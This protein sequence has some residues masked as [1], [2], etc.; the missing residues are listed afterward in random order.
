MDF[1]PPDATRDEIARFRNRLTSAPRPR[2]DPENPPRVTLRQHPVV[3][4]LPTDPVSVC[5]R[6]TADPATPP[7][8]LLAA[9][10]GI[11]HA[12]DP[13]RIVPVLLSLATGTRPTPVR[14]AAIMGLRKYHYPAVLHALEDIRKNG[15][16]DASCAAQ[17]VLDAQNNDPIFCAQC[18]TKPA[19][20]A[21]RGNGGPDDHPLPFF[22]GKDCAVAWA[23]DDAN[24]RAHVCWSDQ[25][26]RVDPPDR[27]P[28][29]DEAASVGV[30]CDVADEESRFVERAAAEAERHME[31]MLEET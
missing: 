19:T 20:L 18:R 12:R 29:C 22:C 13:Y 6:M 7:D 31:R 28:V 1:P 16:R 30:P 17:R 21:R 5:A 9:I 27:C 14:V 25:Q 11:K 24:W 4:P 15:T 23:L 3:R 10:D 2:K 8:R 26:W